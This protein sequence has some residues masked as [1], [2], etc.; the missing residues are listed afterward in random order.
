MS[1]LGSGMQISNAPSVTKAKTGASKIFAIIEEKSL[2]NAED[3]KGNKEIKEG[4]IEFRDVEFIYPSRKE[5]TV[6][7]NL[8]MNIPPTKKIALVGHSGC[9][10]STIAN[11]LLRFYDV[12]KG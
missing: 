3:T 11:L 10:K 1:A 12:E 8:S 7:D 9:G 4:H 2:I 5:K 6:L